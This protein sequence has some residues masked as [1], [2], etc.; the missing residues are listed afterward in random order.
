MTNP[1]TVKELVE[2][3]EAECLTPDLAESNAGEGWTMAMD[4][5][6][7]RFGDVV[8]ASGP[9]LIVPPEVVERIDSVLCTAYTHDLMVGNVRNAILGILNMEAP[10]D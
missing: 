7:V 10:D 5:L 6:I 9:P 2:Q 3:V 4:A 8:V 1:R